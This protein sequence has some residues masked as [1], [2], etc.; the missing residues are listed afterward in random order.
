MSAIKSKHESHVVLRFE[1]INI[2]KKEVTNFLNKAIVADISHNKNFNDIV[3]INNDILVGI[4]KIRLSF[5]SATSLFTQTKLKNRGKFKINI[6]EKSSE[7]DKLILLSKDNIFKHQPWVKKNYNYNVSI[8]ELAD[9]VE[10]CFKLNK[11]KLF[12]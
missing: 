5:K 12:L 3:F 11:L 8:K 4:Y 9:I 2:S 1:N 7:G 6:F 10:L